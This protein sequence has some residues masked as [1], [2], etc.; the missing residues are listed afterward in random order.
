[1]NTNPAPHEGGLLGLAIR[2]PVGVTMIVLAL[3]VFGVVGFR[4]LQTTLLPELSYPTVT[5][6][7]DYE[8]A[9][10]EDV[11]ER[12]SEPIREAVS[13]LGSVSKVTSISRA[14]RSDVIVEF[15]WGT[16][17][18]NATGDLREKLDR[19]FLPGE[20]SQPLILRYDPSL[21]PMLVLGLSGE[22]DPIAMR[23][24]AEE[25]LEKD[26]AEIDGVAAVKVKGGDE[27]E[28]LVALDPTKIT[29]LGLDIRQIASQIGAENLNAS[30]GTLEEAD[31]EY[32]VRA[33]NEFRN[34]DELRNVIVAR[35]NDANIRLMDVATVRTSPMER[36]VITHVNGEPVVLI[37]IYKEADANLVSLATTVKERTFG[38]EEQQAFVEKFGYADPPPKSDKPVVP[39]PAEV[40]SADT[41]P[42]SGNNAAV[43]ASTTGASSKGATSTGTGGEPASA[44]SATLDAKNA[45][46]KKTN[47]SDGASSG[48]K[49]GGGRFGKD[50]REKMRK[51][52]MRDFLVAKVAS[53]SD[54][55]LTLLSDPSRYI[56]SSIR[57]VLESAIVGGL[58]AVIVLFLFLRQARPTLLIS[59]AIP[60]SLV[61]TFAPLYLS[62]VTLNVMSL[63]GLALG[64]GMLVDTSIVVLESI[65]RCREEGDGLRQAAFR[66]VRE[67]SSAVIAST[68]TTVAVFLPIVFV[69]GIAGQL[70]RDQAL[71]VVFSL[72]VSLLVALFLLPMLASR[73]DTSRGVVAV[74]APRSRLARS[75]AAVLRLVRNAVHYVALGLGWLFRLPVTFFHALY[76]P[77]ERLYPPILN[78][79]LRGRWAV[80]LLAFVSFGLAILRLPS[81]GSEVLP[82]VHQGEFQVLAFLARDVDVERTDAVITPLEQEIRKIDGVERTFLTVGVDPEELRSSEEGKH[83]A[84]I[85]V[86]LTKTTS[87]ME[88]L[89]ERV[90][91]EIRGLIAREP[92]I[93]NSRFQAPTLFTI[94]TPV[95]VEI[96][97]H[98]LTQLRVATERVTA[99]LESLPEIR[100]VRATLAR[101]NTEV[102]VRFDRDK[103]SRLGLEIGE[104]SRRLAT[105]VRGEVPTQYPER[106]KK[107]DIRVRL[108]PAELEGVQK[109][110]LLDLATNGA[111]P[112][113][114]G[115]IASLQ[116]KEGPS[117]IRRL[118]GRRAAEVQGAVAGL[119]VG[120]VQDRV[121]M[122]L[123]DLE[124]PSGVET[125]IGGQREEMEKSR[126]S[127]I[128]ALLLAVFLVYVVMAAQF[129]SL[130]QPLIILFSV[131][132]ALTG[133]VFAL[134]ALGI[135]VSVV[136]FLGVIMLAGIV[137]NNAIVLLDRINQER[138][139]GKPVLTAVR[140]GASV[141]LRPVLMT[142]LT[143]VL[144]LLPLTGW[145]SFRLFGG[146][147]EGVEL[148]A[149]M[150]I[151]VIAGLVFSTILTLVVIPCVYAIVI[152]DKRPVG[153][154]TSPVPADMEGRE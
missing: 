28:V 52:R 81:L 25:E 115:S 148:R 146:S 69:E 107:I 85:H 145:I 9:S 16:S 83:S 63:G 109:L 66:G 103:L 122:L 152:R 13:V 121:A 104:A 27:K 3:V 59:L 41:V 119:D 128:Q 153:G 79:A 90:R 118:G 106:E 131:P 37:E 26:L 137:V 64:V 123:N 92:A 111:A 45:D 21:D 58:L 42:V 97:G 30:A 99:L 36:E 116:L 72:L 127:M 80:V 78:G 54:F 82:E 112:I 47:T 108:D 20:A 100:D 22:G 138:D 56:E 136:V 17:M 132:L 29:A 10:P 154:D 1:M 70:F 62:E 24:L 31:T 34:L 60:L 50:F 40:V 149:P 133:V 91:G 89:E 68:L 53:E 141:R 129:E 11:E 55:R 49:A 147:G 6:R 71:A 87:D 124:L 110:E 126:D 135:P 101:G 15:N 96:Y 134:D 8:G 44:G 46:A 98:D 144:G 120:K 57:E 143:T 65:T 12:V 125:A 39:A 43:A 77:V 130:M 33:L 88:A 140:D 93:L 151:T 102:V 94:A 5:I 4:K 61:I 113:P 38:T 150:A 35:R 48:K 32:L 2:R 75:S 51:Q 14:G 23:F 84:R 74:S 7:T 73:G 117:E 95:S 105:M 142:T 139:A 86:V 18:M 114:L 76:A 19:A 67:V